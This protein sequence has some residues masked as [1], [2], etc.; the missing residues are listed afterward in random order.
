MTG[1]IQELAAQAK[2]SVPVG[3][4]VDEWIEAYN[5]IFAELIVQECVDITDKE[6]MDDTVGYAILEHFG[7]K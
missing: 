3:L 6:T 1:R 2:T 4:V 5:R 7:I